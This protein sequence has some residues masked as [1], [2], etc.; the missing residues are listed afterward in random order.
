MT[1]L[2]VHQR[3]VGS[4]VGEHAFR[5]QFLGLLSDF[6]E[7]EFFT[8]DHIE[9]EIETFNSALSVFVVTHEAE[10]AMV[11]FHLHTCM[12][13]TKIQIT[14]FDI[15]GL[16]VGEMHD[17]TVGFLDF[18]LKDDST[19]VTLTGTVDLTLVDLEGDALPFL[20]LESTGDVR[21]DTVCL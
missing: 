16:H 9:M 10:T 12:L 2:L 4:V 7:L 18:L 20:G 15:S 14:D 1:L 17:G 5:G 6:F 8:I 13:E 3:Q 21:Q 19:P 11:R